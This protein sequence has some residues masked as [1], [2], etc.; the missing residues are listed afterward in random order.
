M[1]PD[2]LSLFL[3]NDERKMVGQD[4]KF[5]AFHMRIKVRDYPFDIVCC[6]V[7]FRCFCLEIQ[8]VSRYHLFCND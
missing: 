2:E 1:Q 6:P 3:E 4:L 8:G 5:V 7:N